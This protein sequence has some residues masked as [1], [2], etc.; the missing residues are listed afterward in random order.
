MAPSRAVGRS[1]DL[2]NLRYN[3][4]VKLHSLKGQI[5]KQAAQHNEDSIQVS[6]AF[7][8]LVTYNHFISDRGA[9]RGSRDD[10]QKTG[11]S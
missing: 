3:A 9:A 2:I 8:L 7:I 6:F 5:F 4:Y 11:K 10:T 1:L